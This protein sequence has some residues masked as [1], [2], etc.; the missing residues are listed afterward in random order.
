MQSGIGGDFPCRIFTD[1]AL[2]PTWAILQETIF[3]TL[4]LGGQIDASTLKTLIEQQVGQGEVL[5]GLW[6]DDSRAKLLPAAPYQGRVIDFTE[7]QGALD[8]WLLPPPRCEVRRVDASLFD[9]L[10][11]RQMTLDTF[12][13]R[14]KALEN[15][16]GYVLLRDDEILSEA[17]SGVRDGNLIEVGVQTAPAHRQQ[18]YAALVCAHLIGACEAAGWQTYW[19]CNQANVASVKLAQKLGYQRARAYNLWA[20]S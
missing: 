7:R 4:Y 18:G 5:L 6:D 8:R 15:F 1:H 19:N 17:G 20:W 10:S 9:R 3:G 14:E 11:D 16:I 13:S 12:G 2:Q